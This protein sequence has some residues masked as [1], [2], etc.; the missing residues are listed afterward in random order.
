MAGGG[1]AYAVPGTAAAGRWCHAAAVTDVDVPDLVP[2][3]VRLGA[4][5]DAAA[6]VQGYLLTRWSEPHRSY[7]DTRHLGEVLLRVDLLAHHAERPDL[8]RCA[9]WW[10]DAVHD[11]R[12]G[13]D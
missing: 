8:V 12:A 10:H 9:A 5:G 2:V 4:D 3:L 1:D 13:D 6:W 11:G 7:H